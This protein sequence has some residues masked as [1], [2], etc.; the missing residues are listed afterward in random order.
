MRNIVDNGK[1]MPQAIELEEAII[2]TMLI[3]RS[4]IIE[5]SDILKPEF[6]Y[7]ESNRIIYETMLEL[8]SKDSPIDLLI[9]TNE[10]R[11]KGKLEIVGGA[12]GMV[13]LTQRVASSANLS[14]HAKIVTERYLKRSLIT[15]AYRVVEKAYDETIDTFKL[16]D[17]SIQ[18]LNDSTSVVQTNNLK[19]PDE[20][21]KQML[22]NIEKLRSNDVEMLGVPTG[23]IDLDKI[24]G[25]WV[26]GL[27][28]IA[29]RPSMGKT[30][31]VLKSAKEAALNRGIPTM[32]FSLETEAVKL[33]TRI[34]SMETE[35]DAKL[36]S[37][38]AK[39][40]DLDHLHK[41]LAENK[42]LY[43]DTLIIDDSSNISILQLRA[44]AKKVNLERKSKN[45]E[46][47]GLIIVDY[48]QLMTGD[49]NNREQEISQISRGLKIL[50]KELD[51]PV[52][53]LSQLSRAVESRPSKRPQLSDLRESGSIEQDA[54]FVA[55]LYRPEYYG[56][57]EDED[58]NS[59][60]EVAILIIAKNRD[61]S[62]G[63]LKLRFIKRYT[64]F[65]DWNTEYKDDKI[66]IDKLDK[67]GLPF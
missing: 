49:S 43:S 46:P 36:L 38:D 17:E 63:D 58:G 15:H 33:N 52:I 6:F 67:D 12:S 3:E 7:K 1:L 21:I 35:I 37:K 22:Y 19:R 55:F 56:L 29:A 10:L 31:L 53:A 20:L 45:L 23:F 9:L 8:Q 16:I 42:H 64:K 5:V 65:T 18:D 57:D 51:V 27:Y 50:S 47:I 28:I 48:L 59:T 11:S 2:G 14:H 25:G 26:S 24:T 54:D 4:A 13:G 34:V 32:I 40:L 61:G 44:K 30:A 39:D 41:K 60:L 62:I 66:K